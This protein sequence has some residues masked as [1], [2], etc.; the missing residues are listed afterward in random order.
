MC[1]VICPVTQAF[2]TLPGCVGSRVSLYAPVG[3]H[4]HGLHVTGCIVDLVPPT[5]HVWHQQRASTGGYCHGI[6]GMVAE[7]G[8]VR[9]LCAQLQ[10]PLSCLGASC[11]RLT[12][13]RYLSGAC[14]SI[15]GSSCGLYM[16]CPAL[17]LLARCRRCAPCTPRWRRTSH[18][19]LPVMRAVL[20]MGPKEKAVSQTL[21]LIQALTAHMPHQAPGVAL[22]SCGVEG[23]GCSPVCHTPAQ[24]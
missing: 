6:G 15:S 1:R 17:H 20:T 10:P 7:S 3:V 23:C 12:S 24:G 9:V 11:M 2:A 19:Q 13:Q 4:A 8:A 22:S 16:C 14:T 5:V 18:H 21:V